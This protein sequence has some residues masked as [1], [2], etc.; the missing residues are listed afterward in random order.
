MSSIAS[1]KG[2]SDVFYALVAVAVLLFVAS[3]V[4]VYDSSGASGGGKPVM[5]P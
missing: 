3:V 5:R 2:R 4:L 1:I